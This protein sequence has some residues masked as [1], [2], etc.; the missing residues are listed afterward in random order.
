MGLRFSDALTLA[1]FDELRPGWKIHAVHA[2][3]DGSSI[4]LGGETIPAPDRAA[5][6]E[7]RVGIV[8]LGPPKPDGRP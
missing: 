5:P 8:D 3:A 1:L 6:R 7:G 2:S 4:V